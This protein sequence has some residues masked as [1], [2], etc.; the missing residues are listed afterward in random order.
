V[1]AEAG[2]GFRGAALWSRDA[3]AVGLE[4]NSTAAQ[5]Q[6]PDTP[7]G[8]RAQLHQ[9]PPPMM[10]R[11]QSAPGGGGESAAM[12]PPPTARR[13]AT[14]MESVGWPSSASNVGRR[15]SSRRGSS[16][17]RPASAGGVGHGGGG[18][19]LSST[20]LQ[21]VLAGRPLSAGERAPP[22]RFAGVGASYPPP[23][24]G[25]GAA[26]PWVQGSY[27]RNA[28]LSLAVRGEDASRVRATRSTDTL[29]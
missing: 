19:V 22:T 10:A 27:P 23:A 24:G 14:T 16:A 9:L 18:G 1:G 4:P 25:G 3:H 20:P 29:N 21:R 7:A 6:Q 13:L 5:R 15:S 28:F 11:P 17:A 26:Q 8:R 2:A 12:T